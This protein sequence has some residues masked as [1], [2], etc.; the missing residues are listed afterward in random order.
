MSSETVRLNKEKMGSEGERP[1]GGTLIALFILLF[2]TLWTVAGQCMMESDLREIESYFEDMESGPGIVLL[3]ATD[4]A[5]YELDTELELVCVAS[6]WA[7][8]GA[9]Q[10][11]VPELAGL[12]AILDS[13]Q[14]WYPALGF[15]APLWVVAA[16]FGVVRH[17]RRRCAVR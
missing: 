15:L 16:I 2:A 9:D 6:W 13:T 14:E 4:C 3:P 5:P 10:Y 17:R 1:L 8:L 12:D 7:D 11:Q